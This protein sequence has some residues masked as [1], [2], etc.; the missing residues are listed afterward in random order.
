MSDL[1]NALKDCTV[2]GKHIL[3]PEY[4]IDTELYPKVKR[5]L[6]GIG[7]LWN[8][9][10]KCFIFYEPPHDL[11][12]RI[13]AGENIQ[14]ERAHKKATQFFHTP[15]AVIEQMHEYFFVGSDT[16]ILEPH[17]GEGHIVD[18]IHKR[19]PK[20]HCGWPWTMDCCE[21]DEDRCEILRG[22]GYNVHCGDFL[23]ANT[24]KPYHLVIANPPFTGHQDV[25][26][27]NH[28]KNFIVPG[29]R[30][31]TI[32]SNA[33]RTSNDGIAV[34]FR[35]ELENNFHNLVDL[36]KNSFRE[37]GTSIDACLVTIDSCL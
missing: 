30:I 10:L 3:L 37:A 1:I 5:A 31:I 8:T 2:Q 4:Q 25:I 9:S 32:M 35:E 33:W 34:Q 18:W 26:H 19:Y 17:A 12:K 13:C 11:F 28:M 14:L 16:S 36:P 21:Q 20:S 29:G 22:K 15:D 23:K 24:N 6:T 7:G 27:V